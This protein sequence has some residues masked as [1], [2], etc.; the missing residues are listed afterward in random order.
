LNHPRKACAFILGGA[1]MSAPR[2]LVLSFASNPELPR[3]LPGGTVMD[4]ESPLVGMLREVSEETGLEG[5]IVV[6][7][8]GIRR[9][10]KHYTQSDVERHD[11]LLRAPGRVPLAFRHTVTGSGGDTGEVFEF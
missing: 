4:G 9:Y 8:L 11:Y 1:G 7:K 10:Y 2:L 3:R 5:L 6:R